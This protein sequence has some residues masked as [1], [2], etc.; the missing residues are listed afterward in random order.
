[1]RG[2][3]AELWHDS[4]P[5]R[6]CPVGYVGW[7]EEGLQSGNEVCHWFNEFNSTLHG[8]EFF[9]SDWDTGRISRAELLRE[10]NRELARRSGEP[11][12]LETVEDNHACVSCGDR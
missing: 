9:Y 6:T 2:E 10:V 5:K 12:D 8:A 1:M 11:I 3:V 4:M 7:K